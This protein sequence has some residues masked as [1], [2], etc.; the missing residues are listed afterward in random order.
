MCTAVPAGK[1]EASYVKLSPATEDMVLC[2]LAGGI[3]V[4]R[5]PLCTAPTGPPLPAWG[6]PKLLY[7]GENLGVSTCTFTGECKRV[8]TGINGVMD[9]KFLDDGSLLFAEYGTGIWKCQNGA[10]QKS[11]CAQYE[12]FKQY[13]PLVFAFSK[14]KNS[15]FLTSEDV[16][17]GYSMVLKKCDAKGNSCSD[18]GGFA[19]GA[20][21]E[22]AMDPVTGDLLIPS[23]NHAG[24]KGIYRCPESG[25]PACTLTTQELAQKPRSMQVLPSGDYLVNMYGSGNYMKCPPNKDSPCQEILKYEVLKP[26]DLAAYGASRFTTKAYQLP[27]GADYIVLSPDN[28][29]AMKCTT[30]QCTI[31]HGQ[32]TS[33]K[34]YTTFPKPWGIAF[35]PE[36]R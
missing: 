17:S 33:T 6:E 25:T 1:C 18:F 34:D 12:N 32:K 5:G 15:M 26:G 35:G 23:W 28:N 7:A 10:K 36:W 21:R 27:N 30:S 16:N 8:I 13:R 9:M 11:D 31:I 14:D 2:G 29:N 24:P 4:S 20:V 3:C 19:K 22:F